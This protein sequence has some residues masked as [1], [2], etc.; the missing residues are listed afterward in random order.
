FIGGKKVCGILTEGFTNFESGII[1]SA[2]VGIGINIS[3]NQDI[4]NAN[5]IAGSITGDKEDEKV[6]RCQLAALVAGETL[7]I[8]E[9]DPAKVMK[10]YRDASFLIGDTV[11]VHPI[12]GDDKSAYMAKVLDIDDKA[13][14][15]VQLEDG[16]RKTL[17][18][19]EVSLH[20]E[21]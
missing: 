1:E 14:L 7:K 19:G 16:S 13:G 17:N 20:S 10:E 18:S 9:E 3:D 11:Q 21:I 12:I 4:F 6:T 5:K 2:V 15:L 8:F